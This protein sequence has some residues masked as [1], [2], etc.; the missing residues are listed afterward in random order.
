MYSIIPILDTTDQLLVF[1]CYCF[2]SYTSV[3]LGLF[4]I[5][6]ITIDKIKDMLDIIISIINKTCKE[7]FKESFICSLVTAVL[8]REDLYKLLGSTPFMPNLIKYLIIYKLNI[9]PNTLTPIVCP[10]VLSN[11]LVAI[12]APLLLYSTDS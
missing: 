7:L 12:A 11:E 8:Y 1:C 6:G 4:A 5:L 10:N 9:L 2:K 3:V